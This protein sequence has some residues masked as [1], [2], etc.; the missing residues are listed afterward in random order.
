M[1]TVKEHPLVVVVV[2]LVCDFLLPVRVALPQLLIHHFL[3]L[4]R[5]NTFTAQ[6]FPSDGQGRHHDD[7]GRITPDP[8]HTLMML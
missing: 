4:Q 2:I 5:R 1:T 8:F 3:N 6:R 7:R